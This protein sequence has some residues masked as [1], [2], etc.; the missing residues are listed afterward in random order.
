MSFHLHFTVGETEAQGDE[1]FSQDHT[2][3]GGARSS[4]STLAFSALL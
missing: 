2:V 4:H 3:S 1:L